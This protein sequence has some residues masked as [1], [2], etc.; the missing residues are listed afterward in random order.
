MNRRE[1]RKRAALHALVTLADE[2]P[3]EYEQLVESGDLRD[4]MVDLVD[5][6]STLGDGDA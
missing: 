3:L 2:S 1:R 4:D 5:I 6:V